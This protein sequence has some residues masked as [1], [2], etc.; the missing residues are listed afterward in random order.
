DSQARDCA[1]SVGLMIRV[2][3]FKSPETERRP[4]HTARRRQQSR[5]E[6]A[7]HPTCGS[8]PQRSQDRASPPAVLRAEP[9]KQKRGRDLGIRSELLSLS[10][11]PELKGDKLVP[12]RR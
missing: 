5:Q 3:A 9:P 1:Q 4:R 8:Y 2:R 6:R 10:A 7:F 12:R 11:V